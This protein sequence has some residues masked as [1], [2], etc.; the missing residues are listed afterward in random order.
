MSLEEK[1]KELLSELGVACA[2]EVEERLDLQYH[3]L[4]SLYRSWRLP[5]ELL[6]KLVVVNS[7]VTY[8]LSTTGERWWM[9][10]SERLRDLQDALNDNPMRTFERFLLSSRGNRRLIP[11]KLKRAY[12]AWDALKGLNMHELK[13]LYEDMLSL[14]DLLSDALKTSKTSKTIV[15]SVKMY[16]YI[17]R[18]VLKRFV[19]YPFEI[20]VPLDSR[21]LRL[22][23]S[24][25]G[26]EDK[27]FLIERWDRLAR[28]SNVPPLHL[29]S[30]IWVGL[31]RGRISLEGLSE[32]CRSKYE[33]LLR[34]LKTFE[35]FKGGT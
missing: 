23:K 5:F 15:F 31:R 10:F 21:L 6:L 8:Q 17:A 16:G 20:G 29:D 26:R 18:E 22:S 13:R 3:A 24:I 9:E 34:F 32:S 11:P 27:G 2:R 4:Y 7:L 1:L 12:K 33:L 35:T 25:W 14:R 19:P 28:S 30:L